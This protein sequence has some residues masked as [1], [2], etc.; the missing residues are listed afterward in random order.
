[1]IININALGQIGIISDKQPASLPPNAFSDAQ[2]VRFKDGQ[3]MRV[4]GYT[5]MQTLDGQG[6]YILPYEYSG[7]AYWVLT[8]SRR[9]YSWDG[10][11]LADITRTSNPYVGDP[12]DSWTGGVYNGQTLL[13][14]GKDIPQIW[15][16]DL[17]NAID[18]EN[19]PT[20]WR[21][22][23]IRPFRNFVIAMNM[24]EDG[25]EYPTKFRWS[26]VADP[27]TVPA[28]WIPDPTNQAGDDIIEETQGEII[29]ADALR[30]D[31]IIYK[32]DSAY[33]MSYVGGQF[34][35]ANRPALKTRGILAP[36]CVKEFEIG[37]HFVVDRGDIYIHDGNKSESILK[38]RAYDKF[39]PAMD[40]DNFEQSYVT[41]NFIDEEVWFCFPETGSSFPTKAAIWNWRDNTWGVRDLPDATHTAFGT[42]PATEDEYNPTVRSLISLGID[43]TA[44]YPETTLYPEA[45]L[46]PD[47]GETSI[48]AMEADGEYQANGSD[49]TCTVTRTGIK[50][51]QSD[52][53]W[54]CRNAFPHC[55]GGAIKVRVGSQDSPNQTPTW[56]AQQTY[57]PE[58]TNDK[59]DFRVT[60]KYL[61]YEIE[62]PKASEGNVSS[63]D[64]DL[65]KVGNR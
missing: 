25:V 65:V 23:A 31:L 52:G 40:Q 63:I 58:S 33:F 30:N 61:A 15:T 11:T 29:D 4:R 18:M 8:T 38:G 28:T 55:E 24:T 54:Q 5:D 21:A 42:Y 19:W 37:K 45:T 50:P 46:Y 48:Y 60:G 7:S 64:F 47:D 44:L 1:M 16:P 36:R 56:S 12:S 27:G 3:A 32:S 14:N 43:A 10:T 22:K 9:M 51:E 39:F 35:M 13:N 34:V 62:F 17:A 6:M 41:K 20:T 59:L 57:T 53:V 26:D 2:N 49:I